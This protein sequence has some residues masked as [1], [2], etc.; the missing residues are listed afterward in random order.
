MNSHFAT[1]SEILEIFREL[2]RPGDHFLLRV[3]TEAN[4]A[5]S[6]ERIATLDVA[7]ERVR[8]RDHMRR[9]RDMLKKPRGVAF[10]GETMPL[11]AWARRL[12]VS[13]STLRHR[14]MLG[15]SVER[16]LTTHAA[17]GTS[18]PST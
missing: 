10:Q 12:G 5:R 14:K 9:E 17:Q 6:R 8:K 1:R 13:E 7:K 4:R 2:R 11:A 16:M 3:D 15:W 18:R